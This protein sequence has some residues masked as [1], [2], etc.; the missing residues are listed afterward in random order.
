[1]SIHAGEAR[2][3]RVIEAKVTCMRV[4]Q[5]TRI[6]AMYRIVSLLESGTQSL[7]C[8][9][10]RDGFQKLALLAVQLRQEDR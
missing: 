5:Y 3:A 7:G 2:T 8:P 1:V 10:V 6:V 4:V 9:K